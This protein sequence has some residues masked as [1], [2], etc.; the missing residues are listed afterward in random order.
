M[1]RLTKL[2][3]FGAVILIA[4]TNIVAAADLVISNFAPWPDNENILSLDLD[5][6]AD[7][8][9]NGYI[10]SDLV[11]NGQPVSGNVQA[12]LWGLGDQIILY[13]DGIISPD[14]DSFGSWK[15]WYCDQS[16]TPT[17]ELTITAFRTP[18]SEFETFGGG[19]AFAGPQT[20]TAD[21]SG[22]TCFTAGPPPLRWFLF[23]S[24]VRFYACNS[25]CFY[26]PV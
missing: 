17:V 12:R 25:F 22:Y 19:N 16:T 21:L 23:Y 10:I 26:H 9:S 6:L 15:A 11:I 5:Q 8:G 1:K 14:V 4:G 2:S 7:S 18:S 3:T 13:P 20:Y 24:I